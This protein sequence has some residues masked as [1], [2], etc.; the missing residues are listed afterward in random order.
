MTDEHSEA[1]KLLEAAL[2]QMDGIIQGAKFDFPT[3]T[4]EDRVEERLVSSESEKE[5]LRLEVS[6]LN[7]RIHKQNER[8][9]ELESLLRER[10]AEI[11]GKNSRSEGSNSYLTNQISELDRI[12]TEYQLNQLKLT[13]QIAQLKKENYDLRQKNLNPLHFN[14]KET[15]DGSKSNE[16]SPDIP[17]NVINNN[18]IVH[19]VISPQD[20]MDRS[21]QLPP[22]GIKKILGKMKRSNSG[23]HLEDSPNLN[24]TRQPF[25]RGGIRATVGGRL[26]GKIASTTLP[27]IAN[28]LLSRKPFM[29]WNVDTLCVW[30][31][32][33]GLSM[34]NNEIRKCIVDGKNFSSLNI[35]EYEAKLGMKNPLHRKKVYL[36][37]SA[38]VD[39]T[40][41]D[42]QG[43]LDNQWVLR[44]LDDVGL[45]QYKE[46]F[47]ECKID[48]RVLNML[49]IDDLFYMKISNQLHHLSLK[50]GI[51]V[52][53]LANFDPNCLARRS[54]F[55]GDKVIQ[56]DP[57][58]VSLWSNFR[59]MEWLKQVD[60]SEY[61]PNLRG[62]GIHGGI[63]IYESR[64]DDEVLA[65]ILSIPSSKTLLRRHLSIRFKELVGKEV[66]Q[67]K[68]ISKSEFQPLTPTTKAKFPSRVTAGQFSLKRKKS[69]SL[70]DYDD[71]LCPFTKS[72]NIKT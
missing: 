3:P 38:R 61:S 72:N 2:E 44:W 26:E 13:S 67:E 18:H 17:E 14:Q 20:D 52:L 66:M 56:D 25:R 58:A 51:Q 23:S 37:L 40:K 63:F 54:A 19:R 29:E 36:A 7:T 42:T 47:L 33:L 22:K 28:Q 4:P 45:P 53:R 27:S 68:R 49:T 62:S 12:K 32:T 41:N 24:D 5:S 69:K 39:V 43:Q 71:L 48:G 46:I 57:E 34:Y 11:E 55:K 16:S 6:L 1:S 9:K 50:R 35:N 31:E 70:F 30:M 65:S 21:I 64:F 60:L 59:V 8:I 15:N 10:D